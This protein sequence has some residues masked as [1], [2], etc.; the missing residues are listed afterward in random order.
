MVQAAARYIHSTLKNTSMMMSNLIGPVE[1]MAL[2]NNPVKGM[3][4]LVFGSPEV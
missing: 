2:A 1:Q 4:F 3:Y